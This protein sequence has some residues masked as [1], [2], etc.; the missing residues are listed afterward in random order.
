VAVPV[1]PAAPGDDRRDRKGART[2]GI[3]SGVVWHVSYLPRRGPRRAAGRSSRRSAAPGDGG[4]ATG[5]GGAPGADGGLH[6]GRR[7]VGLPTVLGR[8]RQA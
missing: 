7:A 6:G 4:L 1:A 3:R 2:G 8:L 5:V